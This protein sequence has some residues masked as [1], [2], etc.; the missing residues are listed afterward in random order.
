MQ[1]TALTI[2]EI[3]DCDVLHIPWNEFEV[4]QKKG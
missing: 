4:G 1:K 3:Y 2:Q